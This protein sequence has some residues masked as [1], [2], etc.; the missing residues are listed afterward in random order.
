MRLSLLTLFGCL[1]ISGTQVSHADPIELAEATRNRC[2]QVLHEALQEDE[3]WPAMHA[4]EALTLA[5]AGADVRTSL[6]PLL[7]TEEDDQ[8]RCGLARELVRAGHRKYTQIMID[9]L[10]G[11][12]TH[13]H[14]HAAESLYKVYELG[15]G[16]E[17]R[18][19]FEQE[20]NEVLRLMA[21]AALARSGNP[22]AMAFLRDTVESG[23][24]RAGR[25]A[26]WVLGRIGDKSDIDAIR[27]REQAATDSLE[28]C[29]LQHSLAALGDDQ[30]KA[31]LLENLKSDDPAERTYAAVFAG[32]IGIDSAQP[33][34]EKLL[35]DA[36]VDVRVRAAQALL[37]L[38]KQRPASQ[39]QKTELVF[40]ATAKHPRYT[41]GS[42]VELNNG[43]LLCAVTEF[44]DSGSDFANAHIVAK[45]SSDGGATWGP[46]RILQE[47]TGKLNVMSVTMRRLRSPHHDTIA[48]F[49]L[50][51]NAFDDLRVFVRF[52]TDEAKTFGERVLVT[53][54]PG[55]HV[56][57]NDRVT[58]LRS[59]RLVVPVASTPNVKTV[60]H[61]TSRCW[62]S[63]DAGRTWRQGTGALDQPKR[64]AME[65]EVIELRD[66]RLMMIARTQLGYIASCY[67]KDGGDTWTEGRPLGDLKGPE[68]PA[69]IRRIPST[70]DLLLVWNNVFVEGAG[71]G[72]R[73]TPLSAAISQDEGKTWQIT[74]NLETDET[75]TYSYPSI[76]FS[77]GK[78]HLT[79]WD[80]SSGRYST[81]YRSLP[82]GQVFNL[83][84]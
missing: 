36:E 79:Y 42:V 27:K 72:G 60:N 49:Y 41:E 18:A 43:D 65:P 50:Q 26:A 24:G 70:G 63:D 75:H 64:G 40:R 57:N 80:E 44:F 12:D 33:Q 48:M 9:I 13:G 11:E 17:L 61:F 25:L 55:Y 81:R 47:T 19:A 68:A 23:D 39:L 21:A 71:H 69:T 32:E 54:A 66:G 22:T 15:D 29:F 73:R 67:S 3:F 74:G 78:I 16:R 51:K 8:R 82:V 7:A 46:S 1:L 31:E 52:S 2:F 10:A 4:A 84:K 14:V 45:V 34:L 53:D 5:G 83:S 28:R 20:E 37:V 62:L 77:K 58:H 56:M 38:A 76:L 59:G 6:E 30:G 35:S